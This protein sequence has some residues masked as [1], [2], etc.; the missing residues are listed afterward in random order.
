M[1][2]LNWAVWLAVV[3]LCA[4][5][6]GGGS[7][8]GP[9]TRTALAALSQ[10]INPSG[11]RLDHRSRNYFPAAPGDAWVYERQENGRFTGETL[12]RRADAGSGADVLITE[13]W[14]GR[15]AHETLR[16][17]SEGVVSVQSLEEQAPEAA[18]R[19]VGDVLEYPEPFYA[20]GSTRRLIRQGDWGA[21]VDGDGVAESF[22]LEFS[23]VLVGFESL[24]LPYGGAFTDV[25]HFRNVTVIMLQPSD[26]RRPVTR[27]TGTED[28]WWAPGIGMVRAERSLVDD[29]GAV[30]ERPYTLVLYAGTVGGRTLFSPTTD[31]TVTKIA[32]THTDMVFD[33]TRGRYYASVP[34]NAAGGNRIAI[35]DAASGA[36]S[37]SAAA[38]GSEPAALALSSDDGALYV[39]LDGTGEVV[40]LRLP[41]MAELWRARLPDAGPYGQLP[42]Q[43]IAVSPLDADMV[44]VALT[45]PYTYPRHGE[46][47][48]IRGGVVQPVRTQHDS[49]TTLAVFDADGRFVYVFDSEGSNADLYRIAVLSDG[50]REEQAVRAD[51]GPYSRTLDW[52][53]GTLVIGTA[54]YRT[55][56][57]TLL[58]RVNIE[59][60]A[61]RVHAVPGRLVCSS[62]RLFDSISDRSLAVVDAGT[63]AVLTTPFYLRSDDPALLSKILPGPAGQVALRM[64]TTIPG[65]PTDSVWLFTSPALK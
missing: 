37:Y 6:G 38:V 62:N 61:C 27:V 19:T 16:R 56:E 42:V 41:D 22:R 57:M 64:K 32:L 24:D 18:S 4:C 14:I 46:V 34:G 40:K 59:G 20:A 65:P 43:S 31:G 12:T 60:T 30:V 21:D 55:P 26:P 9:V 54:V 25:A 51:A 33:R 47:A 5:G 2:R 52:S 13:T 3:M 63:L 1:S 28:I 8:S 11:E 36:L 15:T 39:G 29:T 44:A 35:V 45:R 7:Q 17:T 53:V 58:G 48:L 23:Q 10:D 50:L 49:P